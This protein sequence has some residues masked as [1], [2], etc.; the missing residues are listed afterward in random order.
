MLRPQ[1]AVPG[2]L[3]RHCREQPRRSVAK[4]AVT[5][6]RTTRHRRRPRRRRL[7]GPLRVV[8]AV[9]LACLMS[10]CIRTFFAE[11]FAI[12]S[13]SMQNTL[14]IGD[15]VL[16]DK[17][18]PWFGAQPQ[19]GE[20]VVFHDP[21]HWL[22]QEERPAPPKGV[23]G[24]VRSA[25]GTLGVLPQDSRGNLI[26][27]VIAVGGDTV[28]CDA[29]GPVRVNGVALREPYIYPGATPCGDDP[30][31]TV[32]VPKGALWVMGDHRDNSADSRY[33]QLADPGAGFVPVKDVVGRAFAVVWPVGQWKILSIPAGFAAVAAPVAAPGA[34]AVTAA[35][36]AALAAGTLALRRRRRRR[37]RRARR[38]GGAAEAT[39][40]D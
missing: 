27:R 12:P 30:V 18:T 38:P 37:R 25:L 31:G 5:G 24:A 13:G 11:A 21:G 6:R 16:V 23:L 1:A 29:Q 33:H 4:A 7:P 9:L 17:L 39:R 32:T 19:R 34:L 36:P 15:R 35:G 2:A 22:D 8:V 14:Q 3:S 40:A 20:V 10:W 28:Q 26:K